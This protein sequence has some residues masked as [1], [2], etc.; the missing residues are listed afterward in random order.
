MKAFVNSWAGALLTPVLLIVGF[1][2][3]SRP[4]SII[5]GVL[6]FINL[7]VTVWVLWPDLRTIKLNR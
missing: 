4:A 7:I 2:F 5:L 6:L 3:T 1:F